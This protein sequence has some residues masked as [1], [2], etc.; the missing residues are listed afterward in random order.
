[1][2]KLTPKQPLCRLPNSHPNDHFADYRT[3]AQTT[4][5][6]I[7]EL[8]PKQ[9]LCRWSNSRPNNHFAD[10]Q[11]HAQTD[12]LQMTELV[13]KK[14]FYLQMTEFVTKQPLCRSSNSH[15][16][17]HFVGVQ[18]H[19]S[20]PSNHFVKIQITKTTSQNELRLSKHGL[21]WNNS[22][23]MIPLALLVQFSNHEAR[24]T[25]VH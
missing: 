7:T 1:M 14:S 25:V 15:L 10:G 24:M 6:Q 17:N 23:K 11:T 13:D 5:L 3:R 16:N 8:A 9:P 18:T 19:A 4:T 2:V 21:D 12:T 20:R 22:P